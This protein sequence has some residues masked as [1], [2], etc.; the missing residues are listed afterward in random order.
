MFS[1]FKKRGGSF[2]ML[3]GRRTDTDKVNRRVLQDIL[4]GT[5]YLGIQLVFFFFSSAF[6]G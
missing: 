4:V 3:V 5:E 1:G 6:S 2:R